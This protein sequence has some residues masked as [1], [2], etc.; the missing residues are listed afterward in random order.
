MLK[1]RGF[2]AVHRKDLLSCSLICP[3]NMTFE[4][5]PDEII[6]EIFK[7]D[8]RQAGRRIDSHWLG[9]LHSNRHPR[10]GPRRKKAVHAILLVCKRW[11]AIVNSSSCFWRLDV[12]W[13]IGGGGSDSDELTFSRRLSLWKKDL[14]NSGNSD[15]WIEISITRQLSQLDDHHYTFIQD[16][17]QLLGGHAAKLKGI[18]TMMCPELFR[19]VIPLFNGL[20]PLSRL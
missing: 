6:E 10:S 4:A 11:S 14:D 16:S 8:V 15:I 3:H 9:G 19:L 17:I 5:L 7:E 1:A 18:S 13:H 12:Q 2:F 20:S